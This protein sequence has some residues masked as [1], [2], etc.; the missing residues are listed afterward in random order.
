MSILA[1]VLTPPYVHP[2]APRSENEPGS[3]FDEEA[4]AGN[5]AYGGGGGREE[6]AD[7]NLSRALE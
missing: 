5:G 7:L 6:I 1:S 2:F 4:A 3:G